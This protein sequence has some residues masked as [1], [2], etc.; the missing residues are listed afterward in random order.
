MKKIMVFA[1]GI[2]FTAAG[3]FAEGTQE[4]PLAAYRNRVNLT[5]SLQFENGFPVLNAGGK[6][7]AL[8]APRFARDAYTLKP[9]L[10]LTVEGYVVQRGPGTGDGG[11]GLPAESIFVQKVIIDGKTYEA[12]PVAGNGF[13]GKDFR[14]GRERWDGYRGHCRNFGDGG[15]KDYWGHGWKD[16][17]G[18]DGRGRGNLR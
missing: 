11:S 15:Q 6:V 12:P 8:I 3:L 4:D 1:V 13:N 16:R 17:P 14:Q 5:G 9:G 7:Y 10:S 18:R 2:L